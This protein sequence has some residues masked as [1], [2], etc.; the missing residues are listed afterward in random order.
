MEIL[1]VGAGFS[2][3]IL[4]RALTKRGLR[5]R[6]IER[7]SRCGGLISSQKIS[8]PNWLVETAANGILNSD[9]V[10]EI[11]RELGVEQ[12]FTKK[13]ARRRYFFL[14][15]RLVRWPLT[16][17]GSIRAIWGLMTFRFRPPRQDELLSDW[18]ARVFGGE[19][20][21]KF[22]STA[23][24]GIYSVPAKWLSAH[25][26]VG[27]FFRK[28]TQR[29][30]VRRVT[31]APRDGMGSLIEALE[32]NLRERGVEFRYE[33]E[34]DQVLPSSLAANQI[35]VLSTSAFAA[36]NIVA[37]LVGCDGFSDSVNAKLAR[38][39]SALS[40]IESRDLISVSLL[41]K[42]VPPTTGFGVLFSQEAEVGGRDDGILGVLQN[43]FIFESRVAGGRHSETW[44]LGDGP[45]LRRFERMDDQSI[46]DHILARRCEVYG[47]PADV[48][49]S[50]RTSEQVLPDFLPDVLPDVL[51][52]IVTRWPNAI[53]LYDKKLE[54]A[55]AVMQD[56]SGPVFFFGNYV[57]DLGLQ[58]MIEH[59]EVV[60]DQ[61]LEYSLHPDVLPREVR[62]K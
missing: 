41:F 32:K 47:S 30:S 8:D 33:T 49:Q 40:E 19:F 28:R 21:T 6:V 20:S 61:I 3:L 26:V 55:Q 17:L 10:E 54:A 60:A 5:V 44:I 29:S 48:T 22:V 9:Q 38:L 14:H 46:V 39:N 7:S 13:E 53:P 2:G 37:R 27:K 50:M 16:I 15:G 42:S 45:G 31:T 34:A 35:V 58:S 52:H 62:Q 1:V 23:T 36:K 59:A 12:L 18:A 4:A 51:Q 43:G 57:R 24:L 11:F 56:E 25:L